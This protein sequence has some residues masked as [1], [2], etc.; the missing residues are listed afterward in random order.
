MNVKLLCNPRPD[1]DVDGLEA[2][3]I[4]LLLPKTKGILLCAI[5]RPPNDS[6]FL[7]KFESALSMVE[8]GKE[9]YIMGDLNIDVLKRGSSLF[10]GY[11]EILSLFGCE[12]VITEPTRMTPGSSSLIDHVISNVSDL[13]QESGVI[14]A[15]LSDHF[16]TYCTRNL[17]KEVLMSSNTKKIRM[18]RSYSKQSFLNELFKIDWSSILSSADVNFCLNEFSRLFLLGIRQGGSFERNTS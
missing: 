9:W 16:V 6:S 17:P 1:L 15:G 5:Y 12:Q 3:W 11:M 10:T 14:C 7:P 8:P 2:T 4:E 13:I 18:M